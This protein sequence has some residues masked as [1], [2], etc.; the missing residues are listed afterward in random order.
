M[1]NAARPG[2][3]RK[4]ASVAV[5]RLWSPPSGIDKPVAWHTVS[6][7][8]VHDRPTAQ[9]R[10]LRFSSGLPQHHGLS[11]VHQ[12]LEFKDRCDASTAQ[13]INGQ[14]FSVPP[15]TRTIPRNRGAKGIHR[16]SARWSPRQPGPMDAAARAGHGS[17]GRPGGG[18]SR[19][20]C[21]GGRLVAAAA[22]PGLAA[23]KPSR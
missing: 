13:R 4:A 2:I 3:S 11:S 14:Y 8:D 23:G 20:L 5:K 19:H 1:K 9:H 10:L 16:R 18:H 21:G 17:T 7:R 6:G 12:R 22:A 15:T